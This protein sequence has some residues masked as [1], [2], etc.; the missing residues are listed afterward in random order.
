MFNMQV[1]NFTPIYPREIN[2]Y[3]Y[4]ETYTSM[5]IATSFIIASNW[6]KCPSDGLEKAK[7]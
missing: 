1:S 5:F 4:T 6:K 3:V 7:P 2:I